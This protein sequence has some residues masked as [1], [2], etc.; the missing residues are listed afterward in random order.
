MLPLL[1]EGDV[2]EVDP[3][4]HWLH[5]GA[6]VIF[7]AGGQWVVHR[8]IDLPEVEDGEEEKDP[9]DVL[10][11][12]EPFTLTTKG[13]HLPHADAPISS[14]QVVARVL[15]VHSPHGVIRFDTP[16][17]VLLSRAVAWLSR[18]EAAAWRGL[19]RRGGLARL[20]VGLPVRLLTGAWFRCRARPRYDALARTRRIDA[21]RDFPLRAYREQLRPRPLQVAC[22]RWAALL[23]TTA[24][25]MVTSPF[26]IAAFDSWNRHWEEMER[27]PPPEKET[28]LEFVQA[29]PEAP[30]DRGTQPA[31]PQQ[32]GPDQTPPGPS[33]VQVKTTHAEYTSLLHGGY[34]VEVT[35]QGQYL[36]IA[37]PAHMPPAT[38]EEFAR[39]KAQQWKFRQG[40]DKVRVVGYRS[41][42]GLEVHISPLQEKNHAAS[43]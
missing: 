28:R 35:E 40:L 15:A 4:V 3:H 39:E 38:L 5:R 22:G 14:E 24:L 8:I 11:E 18:L 34:R 9:E 42:H 32:T 16:A 36:R 21:A 19:R 31:S 33:F 6:V 37:A 7:L 13:D 27:T 12:P 20:A 25:F 41:R 17:G 2:L 43:G 23:L 26:W 10:P 1:R 29:P 30:A